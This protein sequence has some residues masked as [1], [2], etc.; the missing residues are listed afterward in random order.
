MEKDENKI[1][2]RWDGT[3]IFAFTRLPLSQDIFPPGSLPQFVFFDFGVRTA[4]VLLV[5]GLG[6]ITDARRG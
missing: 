5:V 4:I 2:D 1:C 3:S 6:E